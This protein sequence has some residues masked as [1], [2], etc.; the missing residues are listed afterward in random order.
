[1]FGRSLC[2]E[3]K[4]HDGSPSLHGHRKKMCTVNMTF[5]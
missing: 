2:S 1:M 3:A 4:L 5:Y